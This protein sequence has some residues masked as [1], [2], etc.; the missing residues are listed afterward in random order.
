[1]YRVH[2]EMTSVG[3]LKRGIRVELSLAMVSWVLRSAVSATLFCNLQSIKNS[4]LKIPRVL[5][6]RYFGPRL[7]AVPITIYRYSVIHVLLVDQISNH[8]SSYIIEVSE[9]VKSWIIIILIGFVSNL[10]P[11]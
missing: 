3:E 9:E 7:T 8:M 1:M 4:S 2:N 10:K 5:I 11:T 6:A